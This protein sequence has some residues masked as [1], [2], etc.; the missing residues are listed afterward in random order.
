MSPLSLLAL[1][2][3]AV[4]VHAG[5]DRLPITQ[6]RPTD[7][8]MGRAKNAGRKEHGCAAGRQVTD[9]LNRTGTGR[10]HRQSRF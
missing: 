10:V 6:T 1:P 5:H 9:A 4:P 7:L 8:T 2:V 3:P